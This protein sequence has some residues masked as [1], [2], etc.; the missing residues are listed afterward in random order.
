MD[1][2]TAQGLSHLDLARQGARGHA[3]ATV[4]TRRAYVLDMLGRD[5]E[6]LADLRR[7]VPMFGRSGDQVWHARALTIRGLT[8]IRLGNLTG[9]E[10]DFLR[11]AEI[12][13]SLDQPVEAAMIVHN[14]GVLAMLA[15]DLP[16]AFARYAEAAEE[17]DRLGEVV[18][19]LVLDRSLA[20][21]AAGLATEAIDVVE[22][23]LERP[24]VQDR[25]RAELL[26]VPGE[27]RAGGGRSRQGGRQR[28]GGP[29]DVPTSGARLVRGPGRADR[30]L[31]AVRRWSVRAGAAP[32][33][34]RPR[35]ADATARRAGDAPGVV[36]GGQARH[37]GDPGRRACLLPRGCGVPV[38]R[39]EHHPGV[40]LARD[41][42]GPADAGR[43]ARSAP[44]LRQRP[45]G[46]RRLPGDAGQHRAAR[47]GDRARRGARRDGDPRG[48]GGRRRPSTADLGRALAGHR[49]H[50]VAGHG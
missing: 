24:H 19:E 4:L 9:A 41:G 18:I 30:A 27:R 23:A 17:Y 12:Y 48:P 47:A 3:L 38:A 2:R 13:Q 8:L 31:G 16:R 5:E 14:R 39:R 40:G 36:A 46:A 37:P 49:P 15:G 1:G 22:T 28:D 42:P 11:A 29:T 50:P 44:R 20:Y 7:A 45:P 35:R 21:L 26:L 6:A 33:R 10:R 43:R 34:H 32:R 25:Y